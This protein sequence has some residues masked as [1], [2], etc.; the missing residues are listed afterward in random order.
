MKSAVKST[1]YGLV[2]SD[3][4][5]IIRYI[6]ITVK[7]L[8]VRL[9][10]HY[11]DDKRRVWR[12]DHRKSDWI[13]S[14]LNR[15]AEVQIISLAEHDNDDDLFRSEAELIAEH[16]RRGNLLNL[17]GIATVFRRSGGKRKTRD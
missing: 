12:K 11:N 10:G 8:A 2:A 7:P 15:D 13:R 16:N 3:E 1:I 6:G 4:P 14:V 5:T 9:R 17:S